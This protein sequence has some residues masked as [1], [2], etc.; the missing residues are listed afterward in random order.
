MK[1]L[2]FINH[3][4]RKFLTQMNDTNSISPLGKER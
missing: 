1:I 4:S 2:D 3:N